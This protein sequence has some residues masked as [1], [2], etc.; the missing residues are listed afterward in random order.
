MGRLKDKRM[1]QK[2]AADALW[3]NVRQ[4]KRLLKNYR[5]KGAA[6]LVSQRRIKPSNNRLPTETKQ[7]VIDLLHA[8]YADFWPTFAHEKLV[9]KHDLKLSSGSVRPIMIAKICGHRVKPK[10][11]LPTK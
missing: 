7:V 6:G 5:E 10:R 8:H 3:I 9:E 11:S 1:T 2:K 4:V